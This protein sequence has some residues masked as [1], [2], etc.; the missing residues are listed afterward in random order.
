MVIP[1]AIIIFKSSRELSNM[2]TEFEWLLRTCTRR[3]GSRRPLRLLKPDLDILHRSYSWKL[4]AKSSWI[5]DGSRWSRRI[6]WLLSTKLLSQIPMIFMS[7]QLVHYS[8][9]TE[10]KDVSE[11]VLLPSLSFL[12]WRLPHQ[13]QILSSLV[14]N[15]FLSSWLGLLGPLPFTN[16][17][18]NAH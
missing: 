7:R 11:V 10:L 18:D 17:I 2:I 14:F 1:E 3:G 15:Q 4:I 9:T 13:E 6:L 8:N 5:K 12:R 16:I